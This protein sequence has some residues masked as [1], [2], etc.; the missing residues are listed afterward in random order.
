MP[1]DEEGYAAEELCF[2]GAVVAGAVH[3]W[4]NVLAVVGES[5]GLLEDLACLAGR[6]MPLDPER[7]AAVAGTV[8]RQ[9]RRGNALLEN[10]RRF[11]HAVD[12]PC[13]PVNL[14]EAGATMTA[15]AGRLAAQRG[16]TLSNDQG[17]GVCVA[18]DPYRLCRLL[19][20]CLDHAMAT[21]GSGAGLRLEAK[22]APGGPEIAI[23]GLT[24][25][26]S[27]LPQALVQAA[28]AIGAT[29]DCQPGRLTVRFPGDA[30]SRVL[31]KRPSAV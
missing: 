24:P 20:L 16:V 13:R 23:S 1:S 9:V 10:L 18:C 14:A 31:E 3:E 30:S 29:V 6:G 17:P 11:A 15:L 5:A 26:P 7:L 21:A 22:A 4:G 25:T 28:A 8:T 27:D 2:F 12:R 19:F